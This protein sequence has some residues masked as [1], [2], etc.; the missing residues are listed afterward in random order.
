MSL[1]LGDNFSY[2]GVKP[3]DAR[4][5]YETIAAMKAVADATMYD[6]CLAYCAGTDKTY[7]WKS[8]N[9]VDET[10]G[11][12]R[13][14]TSGGG[15]GGGETYTA[16]DG[17]D[18]SGENEISTEKSEAGWMDEVIE[19]VPM[20]GPLV[21]IAN[22]FNRSDLYST[23]ERVVGQWI[24]GKPIYQKTIN[25]GSY[26]NAGSTVEI[27]VGAN[28]D[29]ITKVDFFGESASGGFWPVP[30]VDWQTMNNQIELWGSGV[31]S[32]SGHRYIKFRSKV[33]Y[34]NTTFYVTVQYTKTTDSAIAIGS[35]NEYSTDEKIVGSWVDGKPIYQKTIEYTTQITMS[36]TRSLTKLADLTSLAVDE[37]IN[38]RAS[39][40]SSSGSTYIIPYIS[41]RSNLSLNSNIFIN[42]NNEL[43]LEC[44]RTSDTM[45][46]TKVLCTIQYTKLT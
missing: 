15:G 37:V 38:Y 23:T 35:E 42:E 20:S 4:L 10:T 6:G 22:A 43:Y 13:E 11:K 9:T 8:G 41:L 29:H 19:K 26:T 18:I 45:I 3:L 32:I 33:T 16:G 1:T 36:S 17:I 31:G 44:Y 34:S 21:N 24:D 39:M 46:I 14:F 7:Q 12:W 25:A 5:K 28:I 30:Y 40:L 2:Q 27:D